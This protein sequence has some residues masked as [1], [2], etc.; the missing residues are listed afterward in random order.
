MRGDIAVRLSGDGL[1]LPIGELLQE[2]AEALY[3]IT[4]LRDSLGAAEPT[5]SATTSPG[6]PKQLDRS[7]SLEMA[8]G[9]MLRLTDVCEAF[10]LSRSSVYTWIAEGRFPAPVRVGGR[11]VRWA[12]DTLIEWRRGLGSATT[13][14]ATAGHGLAIAPRSRK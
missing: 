1:S 14:Q 4:R 9:S 13:K 7:G 2:R 6:R 10:S 3:E 8:P 5:Q 12:A 11:S